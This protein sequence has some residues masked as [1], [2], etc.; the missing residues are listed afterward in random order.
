M[1]STGV[2]AGLDDLTRR[3]ADEPAFADEVARDPMAALADY[4]LTVEELTELARWREVEAAT[5]RLAVPDQRRT[6]A[7]F[8]ALLTV[9]PPRRPRG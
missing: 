1:G 8:F 4:E 6:R 7:G 3:L 2:V 9:A 5:A